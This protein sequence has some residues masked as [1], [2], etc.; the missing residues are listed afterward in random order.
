MS[1]VRK[2][3]LDRIS[4]E[5]QR[6]ILTP[7]DGSTPLEV[8]VTRNEGVVTQEGDAF[9]A[10]NMNDLEGRIEAGIGAGD[11]LI[12]GTETSSTSTNAYAIGQYLIYNNL[13]YRVTAAIAVGHSLVAGVNIT[14]AR[15][16]DE[17]SNHLV[18]NGNAFYFDVHDGE[19]G[20]NTSALRGADTFVPFK[21]SEWK[22]LV[23]H[24]HYG[25]GTG[26]RGNIFIYDFESGE[27]ALGVDMAGNVTSY[28]GTTNV[29]FRMPYGGNTYT[30]FLMAGDL[31]YFPANSGNITTPTFLRTI[32]ADTEVGPGIDPEFPAGAGYD[33]YYLALK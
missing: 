11:V 5:P 6:R 1:F 2:T 23:L 3:W 10:A 27:V 22:V 12:A 29:Q 8:D 7:T 30:K 14:Q 18:V 17:L 16:A 19:F 13:L 21:R 4:E 33:D 32:T 28:R 20:Y 9:S 24:L 15:I 31:Y 25:S 26:N